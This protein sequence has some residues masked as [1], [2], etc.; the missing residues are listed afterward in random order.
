MLF[1]ILYK[2][3]K[4]ISLWKLGRMAEENKAEFKK[5]KEKGRRTAPVDAVG[6][7]TDLAHQGGLSRGL[8]CIPRQHR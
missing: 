2:D 3:L 8:Y 1:P 7:P 4:W 6:S 5:K